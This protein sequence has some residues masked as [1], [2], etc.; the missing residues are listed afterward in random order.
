MIGNVMKDNLTILTDY[1][2]SYAIFH[3]W[4][5]KL[6]VD[7][8]FYSIISPIL[9]EFVKNFDREC[10]KSLAEIVKYCG[11]LKVTDTALW[12]LFEA[13]LYGEKL[14]RYIPLNELINVVHA[15]A[16]VG[17]GSDTLIKAIEQ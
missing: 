12:D 10:N 6:E 13:K 15:L 7:E 11:W 14:Y 5:H 9:K 16:V 8:H 2:L 17:R 1:Q 4:N 3:I